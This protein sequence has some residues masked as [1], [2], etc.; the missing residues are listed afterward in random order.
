M[1]VGAAERVL[2][3]RAKRRSRILTLSLATVLGVAL[4]GLVAGPADASSAQ[5]FSSGS[6]YYQ[7]ST[8]ET[9]TVTI[10]YTG[11]SFT[12]TDPGATITPGTGCTG[13]GT[14]T[15]SAAGV[16]SISVSLSDGNDSALVNSPFRTYVDGGEGND[17]IATGSGSDSVYPGSGIN[18]VAT[19]DGN[20]YVAAVAGNDTINLGAGNDSTDPGLGNDDVRGGPGND[21]ANYSNRSGG[22]TVSLDN[23]GGDGETLL[24][25]SDNVH[26]DI[27]SVYTGNGNDNVTGSAAANYISTGNGNDT[28]NGGGDR[29][30]LSAGSGA[31]TLNGGTGNDRLYDDE[32]ADTLKGDAG[33]DNLYSYD[34]TV[35]R[36]IF[37]GG[38]GVDLVGFYGDKNVTVTLNNVAN[39]GRAGDLTDNVKTD[40]EDVSTGAGDDTVTGSSASNDF[41]SGEGNDTLRGGAG[42]DGLDGDRGRDKLFGDNGVDSIYGGAGADTIVSQD[43]SA[44]YVTCGSSVDSVNRDSKDQVTFDCEKLT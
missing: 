11:S 2:M 35:G 30:T 37:S 18:N 9:N 19:G 28:L 15:C 10:T 31:D 14:I 36:D 42:S 26:S 20:D 33:D 43:T 41:T 1:R 24:G 25:E 7:A 13:S 8:G 40:V 27:E 38:T 39:D 44:D 12:I 23:L 3:S 29:D 4:T 6:L 21:Y 17:D 34:G 22:V 32:G 16:T 5:I